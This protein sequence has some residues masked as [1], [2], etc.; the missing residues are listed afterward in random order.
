MGNGLRA[1]ERSVVFESRTFHVS[2]RIPCRDVEVIQT[3]RSVDQIGGRRWR[4]LAQQSRYDGTS[5]FLPLSQMEC[6]HRLLTGL[7]S[8]KARPAVSTVPL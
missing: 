3:P 7:V 1:L 8:R 6:L 4:D 2:V 5:N